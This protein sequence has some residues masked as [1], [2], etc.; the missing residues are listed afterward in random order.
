MAEAKVTADKTKYESGTH[1]N[2]SNHVTMPPGIFYETKKRIYVDED[3]KPSEYNPNFPDENMPAG[4]K[5]GWYNKKAKPETE[6]KETKAKAG[7]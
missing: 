7:K 1:F 5:P 3:G 6:E 4:V 2:G